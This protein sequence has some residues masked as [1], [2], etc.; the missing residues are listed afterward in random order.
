MYPET[1]IA[2]MIN[3]QWRLQCLR[4]EATASRAL[5]S[6][7]IARSEMGSPGLRTAALYFGRA[8]IYLCLADEIIANPRER[9]R[10][11]RFMANRRPLARQLCL[12]F[13]AP[14]VLGR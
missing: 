1:K 14:V 13:I 11:R 8:L 10:T 7:E 5:M 2:A 9:R 12:A 4:D 6:P 3:E